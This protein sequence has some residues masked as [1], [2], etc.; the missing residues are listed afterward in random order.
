MPPVHFTEFKTGRIDSHEFTRIK[1]RGC[2]GTGACP[3]MGTANTMAAMAEALGMTL[4]G[5]TTIP[6]SDSHLLRLAFRAGE[7]VVKLHRKG[8]RPADIMTMDAFHNA[9]RLLMAIGGST[10]AVLHLQ[11]IAHELELDI[12]S[13][14]FNQLS[15]ETPFICDVIPSGPGNNH[16]GVL[17][18]AGGIQAVLKELLPLLDENALTITGQSLAKNLAKVESGDPAV[19][20]S[21]DNP[22]ADEG[23]LIF[24]KGNLAPGG[25]LI[26]KSAVPATMQHHRGPARIFASEEAACE[27]LIDDRIKPGDVAIV[28][29]KGPKGDPGMRL[30]QRFLWQLA[31]RGM[32]DKIAFI[33]DGRFSGTNKGC[34]VAHIA[35]EAMEGGPL[36]VVRNGDMIVIDI[37]NERLQVDL[38]EEELRRRMAAWQPPK[39]NVKRGYLSIYAKLAK[40]ADKGAALDYK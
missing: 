3:V 24:L 14:I 2:M 10:N 8:I 26:K 27:A 30:L 17:D 20:H 31:A 32:Q 13:R 38:S 18:E 19:I 5:N 29:F 9:I 15:R 33:T 11:S 7:Q 4:P 1:D 12:E 6:G 34:A 40:A 36:A 39:K 25:G 21:L 28:R 23:G 37:P 35:P 22:I 16:L